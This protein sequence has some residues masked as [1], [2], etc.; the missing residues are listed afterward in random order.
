MCSSKNLGT[1]LDIYLV[2]FWWHRLPPSALFPSENYLDNNDFLPQQSPSI[3]FII[4]PYRKEMYYLFKFRK[5][6]RGRYIFACFRE[7]KKDRLLIFLNC[8]LQQ[9]SRYSFVH[10][11]GGL[12]STQTTSEII[13][14][15]IPISKLPWEQ[16]FFAASVFQHQICHRA[17]SKRVVFLVPMYIKYVRG[18]HH[19]AFF[20]EIKY[21][22]FFFML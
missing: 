20:R 21:D 10:I 15:V 2:V 1:L 13:I 19:I 3:S 4:E 7:T 5:H 9:E 17:P 18:K 12:L 16:S 8:V 14:L 11:P 6:V 22:L